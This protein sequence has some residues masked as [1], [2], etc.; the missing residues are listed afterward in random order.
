M[1]TMTDKQ[2]QT[3]ETTENTYS[4]KHP[5]VLQNIENMLIYNKRLIE[6]TE[7]SDEYLNDFYNESP[8]FTFNKEFVN[9]LIWL[10]YSDK[11]KKH[12]LDKELEEYF[13]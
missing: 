12:M 7:N 3:G 4:P 2:T 5:L 1:D 13:N 8:N 10:T 11:E 6:I 9:K